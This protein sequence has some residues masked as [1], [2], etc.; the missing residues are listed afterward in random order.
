MG[1]GFGC[2]ISSAFQAELRMEQEFFFDGSNYGSLMSLGQSA[3]YL[4]ID[5]ILQQI[6]NIAFFVHWYSLTAC[7]FLH[8]LHLQ[9]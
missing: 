2:L 1:N 6:K 4:Y 7:R 8:L 9:C 3:E 5:I